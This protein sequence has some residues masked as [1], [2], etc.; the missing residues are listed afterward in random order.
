MATNH[1]KYIFSTGTHYISNSGQDENKKYTGGKAGDQTGKEW[2]LRSWYNRP[3]DV[4]LRFPDQNV[5]LKIAVLGIE[6]ALND[7]IGYDQNQRATYWEQLKAANYDPSKIKV[8]CEDDCTAGV[9]ANVRAAGY[10]C[11]VKALQEIPLCTSRNMRAKFQAAGFQVLTASKYTTGTKYLLPGDILL[12]ENHHAATNIT[13][14]S[15]VRDQWHPGTP[16][17]VEPE[18]PEAP[19]TGDDEAAE[20]VVFEEY[21]HPI[22]ITGGSVNLRFGP[23]TDYPVVGI[24]HQ[25]DKLPS[26]GKSYDGNWLFVI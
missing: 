11:G 5:A 1:D 12:C 9:S 8:A 14:G 13:C 25:G 6:A 26:I 7:L 18:A 2:C 16:A 20:D 3:F 21:V 15:A 10:L 22:V 23:S 19:E 17:T 24:V 4:I